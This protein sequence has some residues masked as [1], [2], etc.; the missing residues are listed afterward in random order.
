MMREASSLGMSEEG[1]VASHP[2]SPRFPSLDHDGPLWIARRIEVAP[3]QVDGEIMYVTPA[4]DR[5]YGY[6]WPDTLLGQR[7][8]AIHL[9]EDAQMTRQYAVLLV[10]GY[11]DDGLYT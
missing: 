4:M 9:G 6:R 2:T 1:V 8:A 7:I 3:G 10:L 11:A 5:L